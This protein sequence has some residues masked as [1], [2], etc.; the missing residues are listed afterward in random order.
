MPKRQLPKQLLDNL[1]PTF[2]LGCPRG[3]LHGW[4]GK[5]PNTHPG[6][7]AEVY[8][9][10]SCRAH[11]RISKMRTWSPSLFG[12]GL[13]RLTASVGKRR[14]ELFLEDR[15][16]VAIPRS[17]VALADIGRNWPNFPKCWSRLDESGRILPELGQHV[18]NN[19]PNR[20]DR[21]E[22]VPQRSSRNNLR[23]LRSNFRT[24][25]GQL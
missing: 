2:R 20:P 23:Q 3:P 9:S 16:P 6:G 19:G 4:T 24:T 12:G 7:G 11:V 22:F 8:C 5:R 14:V 1:G 10:T 25:L 18:G 15:Q 13:R 21:G 17:A